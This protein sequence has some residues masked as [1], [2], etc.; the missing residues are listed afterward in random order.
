MAQKKEEDTISQEQNDVKTEAQNILKDIKSSLP[1]WVKN[2]FRQY[3][4][5]NELN[6]QK[7]VDQSIEIGESLRMPDEKRKQ[8]EVVIRSKSKST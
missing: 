8:K 2:P 1:D 3:D 6:C 5:E 4:E 7:F